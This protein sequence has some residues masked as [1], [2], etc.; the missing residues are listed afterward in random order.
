MA[1]SRSLLFSGVCG[2]ACFT[3]FACV[4]LFHATDFQS[5]EACT[6]C[7]APAPVD[8]GSDAIDFCTAFDPPR[9]RA[10]AERACAWI[11]ACLGPLGSNGLSRCV[12]S[13]QMAYDCAANPSRPVRGSARDYW[14]CL[15]SA[16]NCDA[17]ERCVSPGGLPTCSAPGPFFQCAATAKSD[18]KSAVRVLC[19]EPGVPRGTESCLT[20]N[21]TCTIV[22]NV[23]TLAACTGP[24]G[25]SCTQSECFGNELRMCDDAGIDRG[26]DCRLV[27]A[28][29]CR[30]GPAG[31]ACAPVAGPSCVASRAVRCDGNVAVGCATGSEERVDCA[32]VGTTCAP[33]AFD[34]PSDACGQRDAGCAPDRCDG[35]DVVS[36]FAGREVRVSCT[37]MGLGPCSLRDLPGDAKRAACGR[38]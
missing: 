11:G 22:S 33:G 37:G 21:K 4:D 27:G 3:A 32:L 28:G 16:T 35:N 31:P 20:E 38:P 12:F 25:K 13:G 17:V 7:G 29:A 5:R 34:T 18:S 24:G 2:V 36:C 9:A 23:P 10:T 14:E 1:L 26:I 19:V 6:D 15:A 8:A 30:T